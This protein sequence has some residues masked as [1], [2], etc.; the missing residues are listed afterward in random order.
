MNF[1]ETYKVDPK[2]CDDLIDY[3][4]DNTEYK[5]DGAVLDGK[6]N[7]DVKDSIDVHFYNDSNDLRIKN[8]FSSMKPCICEYV[9]KYRIAHAINT[10]LVNKIQYYKPKGGFNVVHYETSYETSTRVVVYMLY[11][12]DVTDGGGTQFPFQNVTTLAKKGNLILW[13][14]DFTHPH[15][16]VVSNTQEKY[17]STGWFNYT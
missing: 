3:F 1:I 6:I 14:A 2:I 16:G 8:F 5:K 13:P 12:N 17:I 15:V 9:Q 7:K 10:D 4:H 11:L